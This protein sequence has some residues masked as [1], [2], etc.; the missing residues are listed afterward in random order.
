MFADRGGV[1]LAQVAQIWWFSD[2]TSCAQA[3]QDTL[4]FMVSAMVVSVRRDTLTRA[5][6]IRHQGVTT[7][8]IA[9]A[10]HYVLHRITKPIRDA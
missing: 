9:L 6:F 7:N 3:T 5:G 2:T 10:R 8:G 1:T 4:P